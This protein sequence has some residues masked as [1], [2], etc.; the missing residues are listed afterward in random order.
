MITV[1]APAYNEA[2]IIEKFVRAVMGA[3]RGSFEFELVII[4]DGSTDETPYIL[5]RLQREY[6]S[7]VIVRHPEN[8]GLGA[9]L[10]TGF[11]AARGDVIVTMDADLS[12]DP[13]LIP[14]LVATVESGADIVIAS[15][16]VKGGGMEGV[17]WWRALISRFGN[18]VFGVV[19]KMGVKDHTSGF[20]AYR[21]EVVKELSSISK[22]FEAQLEILLAV[23]STR[24]PVVKEVPLML[25]N[26]GGG[27]SKMRY[28]YLVPRYLRFL[29]L[30][31]H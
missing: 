27:E 26:R 8:R 28:L 16:Y 5:K 23:K 2:L 30:T 22:G 6:S 13:V 18:M 21:A 4:D 3:L 10:L 12:H 15:R 9:G 20:R 24:V 19:L 17:P 7:L 1:L 11:K 14:E 25:K 31:V 29:Y